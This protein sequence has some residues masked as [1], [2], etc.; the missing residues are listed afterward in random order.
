M[1]FE[2]TLLEGTLLR[3]SHRYFADVKLS[4]G[5]SITARCVNPGNMT[6]CSE[7]GSRVLISERTK[8]Q[9]R[10][11]HQMEVIYAGRVAVGVH[12]GR[13]VKVLFESI[14]K[15]KIS[16]V[17][18]YVELRRRAEV[19]RRNCVDV[20]LSGGGLRTCH[21]VAK[22]VTLAYEH[23]AYYPDLVGPAAIQELVEL[24][25]IVR[26]GDRAMMFLLAQRADVDWIRPADHL[27]PEYGNAFRDAVARG[28]EIVSHRAKVTRKGIELDKKLPL[29]LAN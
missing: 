29:D 24:T 9:G 15:N 26:G 21:I 13:P 8:P 16:E 23:V 7:P 2:D 20:E 10:F 27:D 22:S 6:G 5:E 4:S 3:R 18:G 17:A 19:P 12:T 14:M 1:L 11:K 25:D 28:V